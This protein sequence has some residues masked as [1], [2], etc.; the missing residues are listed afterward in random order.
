[1]PPEPPRVLAADS[2]EEGVRPEVPAGYQ[3]LTSQHG[4]EQNSDSDWSSDSESVGAWSEEDSGPRTTVS[5]TVPWISAGDA[6]T[7]VMPSETLA[8]D[9]NIERAETDV[10][11]ARLSDTDCAQHKDLSVTDPPSGGNLCNRSIS[12]SHAAE[13]QR[14]MSRIVIPPSSVP[15]WA[16]GLSEDQW[17]LA[18]ASILNK[19]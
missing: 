12:P 18:V 13:V 15:D 8:N 5:F 4:I 14:A 16:R 6:G 10:R 19:E 2:D 1:M 11:T 3:L 7:C 17:K 9:A